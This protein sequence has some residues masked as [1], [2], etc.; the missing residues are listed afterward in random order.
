V[1]APKTV[2]G[3]EGTR[4]RNRKPGPVKVT[5]IVDRSPPDDDLRRRQRAA[6]E[7][8]LAWITRLASDSE[9]VVDAET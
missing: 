9:K 2:A 7:T 4:R 6:A 5:V 1:D 8:I 3:G